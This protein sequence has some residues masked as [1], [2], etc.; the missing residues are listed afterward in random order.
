MQ[1]KT[2]PRLISAKPSGNVLVMSIFIAA[3]LFF[4]SVALVAQNRQNILLVLSEDNRLRAAN[5]A[6]AGLDL[7]LHV[8]R[9]NPQWSS[10][11]PGYKGEFASGGTWQIESIK[12]MKDLPHILQI[13]VRGACS[14]FASSK[15]R[16]V[17]EIPFAGV[18]AGGAQPTHIFAYAKTGQNAHFLAVLTPDMRWQILGPPPNP[19]LP[20]LSACE[21]PL[22]TLAHE[23]SNEFKLQDLSEKGQMQTKT[24][25]AKTQPIIYLKADGKTL[26]WSDIKIP[27]NGLQLQ[28]QQEKAKASPQP[29]SSNTGR[30]TL[31]KYLQAK[32][33]NLVYYGPSLEWYSAS[34]TIVAANREN[35]Y[36]HGKHYYYQGAK[37]NVTS[38][39][40][41][42]LRD[43]NF[44]QAPA[45]LCYNSRTDSW[46][47]VM[48]MMKVNGRDSDPTIEEAGPETTPS[49]NS[50]TYVNGS[51]YSLSG[52]N[53]KRLLRAT[54]SGWKSYNTISGIS[55]GLFAYK[56]RLLYH[57][58]VQAG[59]RSDL[60][61]L[62][63]A[64]ISGSLYL[65]R[66]AVT[67]K[68]ASGQTIIKPKFCLYPSLIKGSNSL[69]ACGDHIYAFVAYRA[70]MDKPE[71]SLKS[72]YPHLY[73]HLEQQYQALPLVCPYGL[74]HFDG[75][76]WQLWPSGL[77]DLAAHWSDSGANGLAA[78]YDKYSNSRALLLP[79]NIAAAKYDNLSAQLV[80]LNRY[81][82]I[83]DKDDN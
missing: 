77:N 72:V 27:C 1:R 6:D 76:T 2:I 75:Q 20:C 25:K 8:M 18:K 32:V 11:L 82:S 5:S 69:S 78:I 33:Q 59:E 52:S 48:D 68:N 12:E 41:Q 65:E 16:Y 62:N 61:G 42:I 31:T 36:C 23:S 19:S 14:F 53:A 24:I 67:I 29:A 55:P 79:N 71:T 83:L 57:Q 60:T 81:A 3:F 47:A 44:Y 56:N 45:L 35:A 54:G 58:K 64:D 73:E 70:A 63:Y 40:Y 50:L 74:A 26:S 46:S 66:P 22:F 4:L 15:T 28:K 51:L 43:S 38:K 17:E 13:K 37:A 30:E 34:G 80:Q 10:L 21:G 7:A 9:H 39:G 49:Q